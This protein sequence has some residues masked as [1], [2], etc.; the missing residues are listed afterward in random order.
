M[1]APHI[2]KTNIILCSRSGPGAVVALWDKLM[3]VIG[4]DKDYISYPLLTNNTTGKKIKIYYNM[5]IV[6]IPCMT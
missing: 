5:H 6:T 3:L 2:N 4:P 1:V